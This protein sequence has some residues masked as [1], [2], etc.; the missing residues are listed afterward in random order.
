VLRSQDQAVS[1]LEITWAS[2]DRE[3]PDW[4]EKELGEY[5]EELKNEKEL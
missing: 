3:K 5:T 2:G 4:K 1:E